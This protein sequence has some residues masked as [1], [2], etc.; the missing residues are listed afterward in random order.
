[1]AQLALW[2]V[3]SAERGTDLCAVAQ[4]LEV[5]QES[6]CCVRG[7]RQLISLDFTTKMTALKMASEE[8]VAANKQRSR[9]SPVTELTS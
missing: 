7:P 4:Q 5:W 6:S 9:P 8:N 2:L 3:I 1:M